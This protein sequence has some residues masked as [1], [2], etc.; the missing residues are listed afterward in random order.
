GAISFHVWPIKAVSSAAGTVKQLY[1]EA[2]SAERTTMRQSVGQVAWTFGAT[3]FVAPAVAKYPSGAP[4][5][6]YLWDLRGQHYSALGWAAVA[7]W[8]ALLVYG[9]VVA[10]G[11]RAR[12]PLWAAAAAW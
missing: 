12:W 7:A 6:P 4:D 10:V 11:D 1:W 2:C 9:I 3:A 5:N 8:L